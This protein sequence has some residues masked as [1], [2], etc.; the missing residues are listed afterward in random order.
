M[1]IVAGVW[2]GV[3]LAVL[4]DAGATAPASIGDAAR[5]TIR[6]PE[7]NAPDAWDATTLTWF[8]PTVV[9]WSSTAI[10]TATTTLTPLAVWTR[11][12][13]PKVGA[14]KR[15][16]L[17]VPAEARLARLRDLRPILVPGPIP[18]RFILG[19]VRGRLVATESRTAPT[20][21]W[22]RNG[23]A[24]RADRSAVAVIGPQ[25]S[26]KTV[27]VISGIL[28]WDG[29]AILSSVRD[30]L[31]ANTWQNR[32]TKGPV[33]VF[34]PFN[35]LGPLPDEVTAISWSPLQISGTV[36]GAMEAAAVLL[37][38]APIEG[39]TN[40]TYWSKKGEAL[41]WPLL[42]AAASGNKTM[43]DVV[44]WLAVQDGMHPTP[45]PKDASGGSAHFRGAFTP[46]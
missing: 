43:A 8:P 4:V 46:K 41:L 19:T 23:G 24:R 33:Y 35:T 6:L 7:G 29:P 14:E 11:R 17:G 15:T 3:H 18:G 37:E 21:W 39:T 42:F 36:A 30:D 40:A 44:R 27:N 20:Q 26:G 25:R 13:G 16:P 31:F 45:P 5:A 1:L 32:A 38:A 9:Y 10:T 2:A 12:S 22:R 28:E 34:D